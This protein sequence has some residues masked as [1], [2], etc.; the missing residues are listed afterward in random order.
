MADRA[1]ANHGG[2]GTRAKPP[3]SL[4]Y[5]SKRFAKDCL[6]QRQRRRQSVNEA[7]GSD[8]VLGIA[9]VTPDNADFSAPDAT[10]GIAVVARLTFAA[11]LNALHNNRIVFGEFG[12]SSTRG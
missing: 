2:T 1:A 10:D 6:F 3:E 4:E 7:G 5:D 12:D 9:A 8:H 11:A